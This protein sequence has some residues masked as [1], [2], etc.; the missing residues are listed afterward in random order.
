MKGRGEEKPL[1]LLPAPVAVVGSVL[2]FQH[3]AGPQHRAAAGGVV[4]C[5]GVCP[6]PPPPHLF[7][8]LLPST[9]PNPSHFP[10][11]SQTHFY[12]QGATENMLHFFPGKYLIFVR[13]K[14]IQA[15]IPPSPHPEAQE[16]PNP[17]HFPLVIAVLDARSTNAIPRA[18]STPRPC[19]HLQHPH[20]LLCSDS[21]LNCKTSADVPTGGLKPVLL[22]GS[23]G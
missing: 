1:L 15:T 13:K 9:L 7:I 5:P 2:P 3:T 22:K 21:I 19:A 18:P 17:P 23:E 11:L 8:Y 16:W 6:P 10:W 14:K 12:R 4:L 20:S